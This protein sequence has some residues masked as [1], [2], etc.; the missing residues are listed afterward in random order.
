MVHVQFEAGSQVP[1]YISHQ[2]A[3]GTQS[4][5]WPEKQHPPV[6]LLSRVQDDVVFS[7][8]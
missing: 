3:K 4:R 7:Q 2:A 5:G 8:W 6:S 1:V